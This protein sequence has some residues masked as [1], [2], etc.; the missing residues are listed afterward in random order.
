MDGRA[1]G[2][3]ASVM[4]L[5]LWGFVETTAVFLTLCWII[6][7]ERLNPPRTDVRWRVSDRRRRGH[8]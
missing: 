4:K 5:A 7:W 2:G 3:G 6:I 1:S 8:K